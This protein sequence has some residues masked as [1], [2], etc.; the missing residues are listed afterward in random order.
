MAYTKLFTSE[1][2]S[3]GHPDKICDIISDA[4]VD[5]LLTINENATAAIDCLAT[6]DL[7]IISGETNI[8][9]N[10]LPD[11][12]E[13]ARNV[14]KE[15]GYTKKEFGFYPEV[16]IKLII[17]PQSSDISQAVFKKEQGA[18]DQGIMFGYA[19]NETKEYLPLPFVLANEIMHEATKQFRNGQFKH[20]RPDMKSQVTVDYSSKP[21]T[22]HT[23]LISVQ[24]DDIQGKE[25][26]D[27][28]SYI[29][30][31]ILDKV[32][33][34]EYGLNA[35]YKAIINPSG[36]FIK[37]GPESDTGLTGRKIIVDTY[38]G[39]AHHGG[40]AFSGKDCSKV[41][42][43]AAYM[44]RY[45]AK[46]IVATKLAEKIE[47]EVSYAIGKPEPLSISVDDFGTG[48]LKENQYIELINKLFD[49]RPSC[50]V[51]QLDLK[52]PIFKRTAS[53]SHFCRVNEE[54]TW[55][56]LDKVEEIK[57]YLA[58]N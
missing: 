52:K 39:V 24:H 2:V 26:A 42:R 22:V 11:I 57:K 6:K 47:I 28:L 56:R 23:A 31:N 37:G 50:I 40:G 38:G 9:E 33:V 32:I 48:K 25:Y 30:K 14:I 53:F 29:K 58:S 5:A 20:A 21:Y 43:S 17:K 3:P 10:Q 4:V 15:V 8:P 27:F 44:L 46:N 36:K 34:E 41:D 54:F 12:K 45:I 49:L 7:L 51:V 35:D 13:I 1:S 55:E 16:E 18:G 19:C